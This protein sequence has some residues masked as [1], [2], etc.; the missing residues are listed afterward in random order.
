M[1][2]KTWLQLYTHTYTSSESVALLCIVQVLLDKNNRPVRRRMKG[3]FDFYPWY[4]MGFYQLCLKEYNFSECL[5]KQGPV[6]NL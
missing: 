1:D 2:W 5:P 3:M 6:S 4:T